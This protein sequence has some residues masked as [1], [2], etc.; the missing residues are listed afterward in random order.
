M[1]ARV[2]TV[3]PSAQRRIRF[4]QVQVRS[5]ERVLGDNPAVSAG[6]P[7][8]LGAR[9]VV[10]APAEPRD[11]CKYP[12]GDDA[13][14]P[15][16][17][18]DGAGDAGGAD[19]PREPIDDY[20]SRRTLEGRCSSS[21]AFLE[22][23]RLSCE[24]RVAIALAAGA[25]SGELHAAR[26]AVRCHQAMRAQSLPPS[27]GGCDSDGLESAQC[28]G[29]DADFDEGLSG[30]QIVELAAEW[31]APRVAATISVCSALK[32]AIADTACGECDFRSSF[33]ARLAILN[34]DILKMTT[35]TTI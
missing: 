23:G 30:A 19:D 5:F 20:E 14:A 25:S 29:D 15:P 3:A 28:V 27:L 21:R 32:G 17:Y 9:V 1:D 11:E 22:L 31:I 7:L 13:A 4:D 6:V 12:E 16:A 18:D 35:L 10:R 8:T 24:R 33:K 34:P 26:R 2:T